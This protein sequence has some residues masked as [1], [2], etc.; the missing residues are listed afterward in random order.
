MTRAE[1]I[2]WRER[3]RSLLEPLLP[4]FG[5][6]ERR[7]G[8]AFYVRGLLLE[9]GRK[10]AAGMASRF[11]GDEQSVRQFLNQSPWDW[12]PVRRVLA[13]HMAKQFSTRSALLL[14]DTGFPKKGTESVGVSRQ[15]AGTLGKI[16]N[17]QIGVSLSYATDEGSFP[18]D[19]QLYLPE[20]WIQDRV[21]RSKAGV[22][23]T[24]GFERKWEIGLGMIDR[25]IEW[26]IPVA[27]VVADA[28][29]GAAG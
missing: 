23:D 4:L 1:L 26:Q 25:A 16:G 15:Y 27:V 2:E 20:A 18:V 10:T 7:D 19:M 6:S 17:C 28:G 3:L 9:G 24:V 11:G 29:Y 5:R 21:R 8:A 13:Q 14:D 22:P 12:M